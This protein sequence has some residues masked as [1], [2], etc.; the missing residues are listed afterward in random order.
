MTNVDETDNYLTKEQI[1]KIIEKK[2]ELADLLEVESYSDFLRDNPIQSTNSELIKK[3]VISMK[4][5]ASTWNGLNYLNSLEPDNW[6]RLLH[7][8]IAL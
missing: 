7:K 4:T 1:A 2:Q 8:I 6:N 3:I 5:G